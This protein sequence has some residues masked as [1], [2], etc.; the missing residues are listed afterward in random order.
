MQS[1]GFDMLHDLGQLGEA[2]HCGA[3]NRQQLEK[4]QANVDGRFAAGRSA[5]R[6][7]TSAFGEALERALERLAA[8]VLEDDIDAAFVGEC[9]RD[10][11]K[12]R[13]AIEDRLIGAELLRAICF[14]GAADGRVTS[15]VP[16]LR[17]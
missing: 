2:T 15:R 9:A 6:N 16:H 14:L 7:E 13:L 3:E 10:R 1:A 12:I 11:D 17:Y 4:D 8:D 5:A